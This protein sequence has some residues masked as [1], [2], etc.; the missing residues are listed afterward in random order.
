MSW[1]QPT[2]EALACL[3]RQRTGLTFDQRQDSAEQAMRQAMTRAHIANPAD[4]FNLIATKEEAL[5]DLVSELTVGETYFFREP[6]QFQR[7]SREVIPALRH[8]RGPRHHLRVW[9]AGCAS[10]EEAYSLAMVL[11]QEGLGESA[12][13]LGTDISSKALAKARQGSYGE[14]SL[15]GPGKAA[16]PYLQVAGKEYRLT[17]KI[18]RRVI[19]EHLNL[20]RDTYPSLVSG[21]W[22]MDLILC[23]NVLI[24]F[25]RETIR[26]VALRLYQSLAPGGWLIAASSDPPLWQDAP[27]EVRACAD[28]G[29]VYR[30][31]SKEMPC[32]PEAPAREQPEEKFGEPEITA[33]EQSPEVPVPIPA[34]ALRT[35]K[36]DQARQAFAGGDY[37]AAVRMLEDDSAEEAILLRVRALSNLDVALAEQACAK[38]T[39]RYPLSAEFHYV[40]AVL[41]LNLGRAAEA[42]RALRRVLYLDRTL[43]VAHFTLGTVLR[44]LGEKQGARRAFRNACDLC[45]QRPAD[46]LLPLGE[47]E[48]AG[49]LAELA[50]FELSLLEGAS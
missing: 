8:L 14:W 23:R 13:I 3:I 21:T 19:F 48:S 31:S 38:E 16:L 18:R 49:R 1:S 15:R 37:P 17:E 12:H 4:Y 2:F 44:G 45:S 35:P 10:G 26:Q 36:R 32:E 34:L 27:F 47:G 43:A 5:N 33:R 50:A 11:D 6:L 9:S 39:T 24:Y 28:K 7:I 42:A 20:A 25:D 30:R 40:H 41:L 22:G 29:L 46:E